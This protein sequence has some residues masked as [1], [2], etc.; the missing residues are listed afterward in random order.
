MGILFTVGMINWNQ[1][2]Q[3]QRIINAREQIEAALAEGFSSSR[4]IN[5][6][7][8]VSG[9]NNSNK[10]CITEKHARAKNCSIPIPCSHPIT[11]AGNTKLD[12]N[13]CVLYQPPFGDIKTIPCRGI[14]CP[15]KESLI[16]TI[17]FSSNSFKSS[18]NINKTSGLVTAQP[19]TLKN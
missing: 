2:I 18:I 16:Q 13:F 12:K 3:K 17:P 4:S 1:T 10:I 6:A 9:K 5:K 14:S 19:V 8:I 11:L 7:I 15:I